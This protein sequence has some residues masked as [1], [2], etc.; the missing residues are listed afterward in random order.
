MPN[1]TSELEEFEKELQEQ[2]EE[3]R[4]RILDTTRK[5]VLAYAG[6]VGLAQDELKNLSNRLVKRGEIVQK[7][8]RKW[9]EGDSDR[10]RKSTR[11]MNRRLEKQWNQALTW[12]NIPSKKDIEEL[13]DKITVL[14]EKVEEL[15]KEK[16]HHAHAA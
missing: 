1:K 2:A 4:S 14:S 8:A 15:K 13:G 7:D 12:M 16:T 6:A 5:I 3:E 9:M 11:R 10:R